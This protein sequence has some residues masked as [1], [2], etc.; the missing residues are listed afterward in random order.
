ME[1]KKA[2]PINMEMLCTACADSK[3]RFQK[4][5]V[6]LPILVGLWV[7]KNQAGLL[8]HGQ[9]SLPLPI[10]PVQWLLQ[11][12]PIYS[13]GTA[14]EFAPTSLL[15]LSKK[16]TCFCICMK[17]S[18]IA[19]IHYFFFKTSRKRAVRKKTGR[20]LFARRSGCCFLPAACSSILP[21]RQRQRQ[22]RRG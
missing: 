10:H 3:K 2:S 15:S 16:N 4:A 20:A 17:F 18:A 1:P 9:C 12:A 22:A 19:I 14:L 7:H 8:A 6:H 11:L 21:S 5:A 13:G